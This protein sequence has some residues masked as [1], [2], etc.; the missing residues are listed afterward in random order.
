[1]PG[2]LAVYRASGLNDHY[3]YFNYATKSLPNGLGVGGQLGH[4]GLWLD[5]NFTTGCSNPAATFA[6]QRLSAEDEFAIDTVEAWLVQPSRNPD[7][8]DDGRPSKSVVEA[9]PDAAALLEMANRTM[10]SRALPTSKT[11]DVDSR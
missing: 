7:S 2:S 8:D 1:S 4:F 10:Y 6:S 5:S 3:Q 11:D 9:N